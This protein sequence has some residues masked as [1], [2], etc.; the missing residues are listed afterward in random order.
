ML[1]SANRN[2]TP[3]FNSP[4]PHRAGKPDFL[5]I[6]LILQEKR[7]RPRWGGD[8]GAGA[9]PS[10]RSGPTRRGSVNS[11]ILPAASLQT[12]SSLSSLYPQI[13][14]FLFCKRRVPWH[15]AF[16][17]GNRKPSKGHVF[18]GGGKSCS[19]RISL[20]SAKASQPAGRG[21]PPDVGDHPGCKK[22]KVQESIQFR[23]WIPAARRL[24][25]WS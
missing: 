5:T 1:G 17:L 18:S 9:C 6:V 13:P 25:S 7:L 23:G 12:V 10:L 22:E 20:L 16:M 11:Q 15:P 19:G 2:P 24:V 3:R 8:L 14:P 21:L 4:R